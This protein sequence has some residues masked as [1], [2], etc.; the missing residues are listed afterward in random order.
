MY[1]VPKNISHV[2]WTIDR[3]LDFLFDSADGHICQSLQG[4]LLLSPP[5]RVGSHYNPSPFHGP[6][7][8]RKES[9]P[10]P[11]RPTPA[12]LAMDFSE[13]DVDFGEDYD[14]PDGGADAEADGGADSSG[15]SSPSSSSSS[16]A[17][18]SSSSSSGGSSRSS[19]GGA[20]GEGEDGADEGDGEEYDSSNLAA[21]KGA[22]AG[23][24]QDDERGEDE[25]EEVE[26]ERDLFGSDNEDYVRTPARSNYLV[27]GPSLVSSKL[28]ANALGP[29]SRLNRSSFRLWFR[30]SYV[31]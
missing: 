3:A 7:Q 24:Y 25:G 12:A 30:I 18:A 4:F 13:Q 9:L 1:L 31:C 11:G 19:S 15:S 26:E 23:S 29:V 5:C 22:G 16:S 21:T 8:T 28:G 14:V 2:K 20:G 10:V 17:A 27:P 6:D